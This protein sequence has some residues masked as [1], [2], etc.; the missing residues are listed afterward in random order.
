MPSPWNHSRR[1]CFAAPSG[2]FVHSM[3]IRSLLVSCE[4]QYRL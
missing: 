3:V 1:N 2:V 4:L